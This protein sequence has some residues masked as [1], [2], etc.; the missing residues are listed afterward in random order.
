MGLKNLLQLEESGHFWIQ[1]KQLAVF[2]GINAGIWF[3]F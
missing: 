2:G 3:L 1:G